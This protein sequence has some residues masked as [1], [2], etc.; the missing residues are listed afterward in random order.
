MIILETVTYYLL[1]FVNLGSLWYLFYMEKKE[2]GLFLQHTEAARNALIIGNLPETNPEKLKQKLNVE[3]KL[4]IIDIIPLKEVK[5]YFDL[6]NKRNGVY[7]NLLSR[8][9]QS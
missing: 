3:T 9:V 5:K 1:T 7:Y 6:F 4:E 8:Y 2:E